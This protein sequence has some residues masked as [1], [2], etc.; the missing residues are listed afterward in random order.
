MS[1]D[2]GSLGKTID[3]GFAPLI[4]SS[5]S[6][7]ILGTLPSVKSLQE[8]QYYGHPRNAFWW[9]MSELCG[10]EFNAS[11]SNRCHSLLEHK[12]AVWDVISSCYRPGS[13][14]S[15]IDQSTLVPNDFTTLLGQSSK[16]KLVAF[17]GQAACKLFTKFIHLDNVSH[18]EFITLPSTSPANAVMTKEAKCERW[19]KIMRYL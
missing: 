6:V 18:C 7:L 1:D 2:S 15:K 16:V 3:L 10:F 19:R 8:N 11:Y 14:D 12:I 17:N 5:S 9:I 4:T 13:L